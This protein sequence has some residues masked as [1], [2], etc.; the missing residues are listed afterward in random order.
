MK[1]LQDCFSRLLIDNHITDLAPAYMAKF[2]PARYVDAVRQSG[3]ESAM[4]YAC[5][6]NGNCYYPTRCGHVHAGLGGRDGFGETVAGL[7]RENIVPVAYYTLLYHNDAARRMPR[8]VMRDANG[9]THRGRYHFVCPNH[10]D[11]VAFHQAQIAEILTYPVEGIFLDM[12]FWPMVCCCDACREK[13]RR[14]TG[15]EIPSAID[16]RSPEWVR[17]QRF[18]ERVMAEFAAGMS[19]FVKSLR[20]E[21]PVVHQFSPVLHGWYLGQSAGIAA[22]SDYASGDFYG[23]KKQQRFAVKAFDAFSRTRPFEFMTSRCVSLADHTSSKS[24]DELYLHALTTLANGGAYFFID[25]INPDGTLEPAFYRRLGAL[26]ARL[27]PFREAVETMRP[28]PAAAAVRTGLVFSMSSCVDESRNGRVLSDLCDDSSNMGIRRNRVMDE[29]LGTAEV[30]GEL[31]R[32]Y[33]VVTDFSTPEKLAAFDT[34]LL[35]NAAYLAAGE[36]AALRAFV[37]AGG[38]LI[39]TG[40]SSLYNENGESSGDFQLADVF[41]VHFSGQF[42]GA[43]SYLAAPDTMLFT[44]LTAPLATA[45]AGTEVDGR[46]NLPDFPVFDPDRYASIHSNPPGL[47][48]SPFAGLTHRRFGRGE[49]VWLYLSAGATDQDSQKTYLKN[50]LASRIPPFLT[51]VK[52][53]PK[54]TEL[55]VLDAA[56]GT[57]HLLALVNYQEDLPSIPL[58]GV[59]FTFPAPG[60]AAPAAVEAVDGTPLAYSYRDGKITVSIPEIRE[61]VFLRISAN[62]TNTA[63]S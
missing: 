31:H 14:E 21:I 1:K 37:A 25:A 3:V 43:V 39:A 2:D 46:V 32:P 22:A 47:E 8:A 6:H 40:A 50:L 7:R 30:L 24:D 4:V 61:A 38:T 49:C 33:R 27:R 62:P 52:N 26:N 51:G 42:S 12:T 23:G 44:N 57:S 59:E 5:D 63:R 19:A 55:T 28:V 60:G 11:T 20:P 34:L 18:R 41:G 13:F 10:P 36:C 17:F 29:L 16:W 45:E 54:S 9:A 53:L 56:D 15:A 35:P 58:L 48:N